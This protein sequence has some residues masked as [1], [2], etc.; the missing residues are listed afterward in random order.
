M[1]AATWQRCRVHF[2]RNAVA[3]AGKSGRS[4][5]AASRRNELGP[6]PGHAGCSG[7]GDCCVS[8]TLSRSRPGRGRLFGDSSRRCPTRPN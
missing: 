6:W 7:A 1:L 3:H 4:S 8:G 5:C 2:M